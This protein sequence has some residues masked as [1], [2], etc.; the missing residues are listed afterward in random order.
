MCVS[1]RLGGGVEVGEVVF[2]VV[3]EDGEKRLAGREA[4]S[5]S[6]NFP[7]I[8]VVFFLRHHCMGIVEDRIAMV[9]SLSFRDQIGDNTSDVVVL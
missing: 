2:L 8:S 9:T 6:I 5:C 7:A 4:K 3:K 1:M